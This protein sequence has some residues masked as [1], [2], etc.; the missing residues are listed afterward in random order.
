[1]S[2]QI[3][4]ARFPA[5]DELTMFLCMKHYL[6]GLRDKDP[7]KGHRHW[8]LPPKDGCACII[9]RVAELEA[10][11]AKANQC[12]RFERYSAHAQAE[13]EAQ[14]AKAKVDRNKMHRR[15]QQAE[16]ALP[17]YREMMTL[18]KEQRTGRFM[19]ALMASNVIRQAAEIEELKAQRDKLGD[20]LQSVED[21]QQSYACDCGECIDCE[22][23]QALAEWETWRQATE[24]QPLNPEPSE[25][26]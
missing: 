11:L 13:L 16:A 2:K 10:E 4:W 12:A 18:A 24:P 25:Q 20:V 9:C 8:V 15:A 14:L 21:A 26:P 23:C 17:Q 1:M 22:I 19:P 7:D 3:T 5:D 6:M